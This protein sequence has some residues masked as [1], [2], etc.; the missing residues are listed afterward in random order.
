MKTINEKWCISGPIF[1]SLWSAIT[2]KNGDTEGLLFGTVIFNSVELNDDIST[3]RRQL[4]VTV[5]INR[6]EVMEKKGLFYDVQGKIF[7]YFNWEPKSQNQFILGWFSFRRGSALV[8]TLREIKVHTSLCNYFYHHKIGY[9]SQF[10]DYILQPI[11]G[12]FRSSL[13]SPNT[14]YTLEYKFFQKQILTADLSQ[15]EITI[16]NAVRSTQNTT[17]NF[18]A[19]SPLTSFPG[20]SPNSDVFYPLSVILSNIP[21]L[22]SLP[23]PNVIALE[24]FYNHLLNLLTIQAEEVHEGRMTI[25]ALQKEL[26]DLKNKS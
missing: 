22:I 13:N 26:N 19:Y 12:L 14:I 5:D 23:P 15:I 11:L 25:T 16:T 17:T 10:P 7:D 9:T 8:P 4:Q 1:S 24:Q 20:L 3:S 2:E 18:T 21:D 6:F